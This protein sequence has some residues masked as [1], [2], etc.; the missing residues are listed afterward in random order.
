MLENQ[1]K[2]PAVDVSKLNE[3]L[4]GLGQPSHIPTLVLGAEKDIVVDQKGLEETAEYY[5]VKP[6]S[7]PN[8]AHDMMLVSFQTTN[9][10][11]TFHKGIP[12]VMNSPIAWNL[13]SLK[14]PIFL[15]FWSF[16]C[17]WCQD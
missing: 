13:E 4:K 2:I 8:M 3:E 6:I 1:S 17:P 14:E 10:M 11:E 16:Q 9:L 12:E 15:V 7:I 5:G